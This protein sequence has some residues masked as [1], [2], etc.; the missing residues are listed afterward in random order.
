MSA[1]VDARPSGSLDWSGLGWAAGEAGLACYAG[2][3][4]I[5]LLFY[6]TEVLRIPPVW[7]G[8]ALLVP[9]IGRASCRERV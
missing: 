6:A 1:T 2:I 3:A 4:T 8:L 9:Q 5:Y 7:A